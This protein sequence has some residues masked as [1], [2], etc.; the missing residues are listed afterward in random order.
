MKT[1]I[2]ILVKQTM[3]ELTSLVS[4]SF[5]GFNMKVFK[6]IEDPRKMVVYATRR[7]PRLGRGSSRVVFGL[8]SG[9]VLKINHSKHY[10]QNKEE[11]EVYTKPGMANFL[12]KIYV[13]DY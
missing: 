4:E 2:K 13:D 11:L 1:L 3:G 9:K 8:G 12:A 10:Q 5:R 6:K 7:L